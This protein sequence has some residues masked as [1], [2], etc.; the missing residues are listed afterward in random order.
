MLWHAQT[1]WCLLIDGYS[2]VPPWKACRDYHIVPAS[3]LGKVSVFWDY[4]YGRESHQRSF[5][6]VIDTRPRPNDYYYFQ[7]IF[8]KGTT[9][10]AGAEDY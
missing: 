5:V 3:I 10:Q 6:S 7:L 4:C 1:H 2:S 8:V 9:L